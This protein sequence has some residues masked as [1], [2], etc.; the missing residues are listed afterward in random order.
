M[1][2]LPRDPYML[3]SFVNMKLRD[4]YDSLEAL[5]EDVGAD[6]SEIEKILKD[7]GFQYDAENNRFG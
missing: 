6:P 5:C 4:Y 7:A 1:D 3:L 2:N